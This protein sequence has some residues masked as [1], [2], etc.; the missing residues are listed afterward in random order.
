MTEVDDR[1]E[2][3][4]ELETWLGRNA[5]LENLIKSK[6]VALSPFTFLSA[7]LNA[8]IDYVIGPIEDHNEQSPRILWE[9]EL[10]KLTNGFLTSANQEID[11]EIRKIQLT[12]GV[13]ETAQQLHLP[14]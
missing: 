3:R 6:G 4:K 1:S 9:V 12:Q 13:G 14:R 7:R 8:L 11:A 5:E 10:A 2:I